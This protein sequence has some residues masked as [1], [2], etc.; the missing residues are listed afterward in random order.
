MGSQKDAIFIVMH[1][2]ST[3]S[4]VTDAIKKHFFAD[5]NRS[6]LVIASRASASF[7]S[8][9]LVLCKHLNVGQNNEVKFP[10]GQL[11][12]VVLNNTVS[13]LKSLEH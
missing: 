10:C 1:L 5:Q 8:N 7:T 2:K 11:E 13:Q 4:V 12:T 6:I 9:A 3:Q